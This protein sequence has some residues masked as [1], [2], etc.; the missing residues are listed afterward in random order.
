VRRN[1]VLFAVAVLGMVPA[2]ARA[3]DETRP[4]F[5][6][7]DTNA[8]SH[9][10]ENARTLL[11]AG[12]TTRAAVEVQHVLDQHRDDLKAV[13]DD[14]FQTLWISGR[15]AAIRLLEGAKPEQREAYEVASAP[16]AAALLE[17][18]VGAGDDR[19]LAQVVDRYGPTT[20]GIT[21]ARRIAD[22][23][24]E[25]GR[26]YDAAAAAA[27]ALR[28]APADVGL[29]LRRIDALAAAGD[30]PAL[31]ALAPPALATPDGG[32][33]P[34]AARLAA[35]RRAVPLA[36][37]AAG[38][39]TWGGGP[40]HDRA[41]DADP[42][43]KS[44]RW[45]TEDFVLPRS[46][47]FSGINYNGSDAGQGRYL[48]RRRLSAPYFPALLDRRLLHA[49]GLSVRS[50]DL[51]TG[52]TLWA[53]PAD[54]RGAPGLPLVAQGPRGELQGR[55]NLDVVHAPAVDGGLVYASVE[56][57]GPYHPRFIVQI[58][59]T[60]YLPKRVLVA[61]DAAT[62]ARVWHMGERP[63][64][65][66]RLEGM[67]V[68]GPVA[69]ADGVVVA[70]LTRNEER[71][72]V[73]LAGFESRTGR[74]LWVRDLVAGQQEL[75][76]FGQTVK[77]L[78]VG[79]P[80]IADGVAYAPTGLGVFAALDLRTGAVLWMSS[81]EALPVQRVDLWWAT[82]MRFADWGPAPVVV[83]GDAVLVA[84]SDSHYLWC[85][86]RGT[87]KVRW[88]Q[89]AESDGRS[90]DYLDQFL[91]VHDDGS[92]ALAVLSS[93]DRV[94]ALDIR[95]GKRAWDSPSFERGEVPRGRGAVTGTSAWVS[96][97]RGLLRFDLG[98]GGRPAGRLLSRDPWP[99]GAEPGNVLPFP[100]VLVVT[101]QGDQGRRSA[102]QAFFSPEDL[103]R[104]LKARKA[105]APDDPENAFEVAELWR[106]VGDE[107]RAEAEYKEALRL[108]TAAKNEA[109]ATSARQGLQWVERSRGQVFV[110]QRKPAEARA[111]FERA[112]SYATGPGDRIA[113]RLMLDAVLASL[114]ESAARVVNFEAIVREG[115]SERAQFDLVDGEVPAR[116]GALLAMAA[117]LRSGDR[118]ETAV[119]ALQR[120]LE[121]E[122]DATIGGETARARVRREIDAIVAVSGPTAYARHEAAAKARLAEA[123]DSGDPAAYERILDLWPNA[124]TVPAALLGLAER[125][126]VA[127]SH[128]AAAATLRRLVASYPEHELAPKALARLSRALAASGA[129]EAAR[130]ALDA[131]AR[132]HGTSAFDLD[133][134]RF[135]GASFAETERVRIGAAAEAPPERPLSPPLTDRTTIETP[136]G[137]GVGAHVVPVASPRAGPFAS[138]L[139]VDTG[140]EVVAIDPETA[141]VRFRV[142]IRVASHAVVV[143]DLLVIASPDALTAVDPMSGDLRWRREIHAAAIKA[144]EARAG[145]VVL[146]ESEQGARTGSRLTAVDAFTSQPS[147]TVDMPGE[148]GVRMWVTDDVAVV[149][150][151]KRTG[152]GNVVTASVHSLLTGALVRTVP[153][154]TE[155][156]LE[157]LTLLLDART[158]VVGIRESRGTR[159]EAIDLPA[160]TP[161]WSRLVD[162]SQGRIAHLVAA[163]DGILAIDPEGRLRTLSAKDG[164]TTRE[165]RAQGWGDALS[166]TV[167]HA[168]ADRLVVFQRDGGA[169]AV[170]VAAYDR[171]T[172]KRAWTQPIKERV[173]SGILLKR[174]DV[175]IATAAISG[176]QRGRA[177]ARVVTYLVSARDGS[178]LQTLQNQQLNGVP[179]AAVFDGTLLLA[180]HGEAHVFR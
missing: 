66:A 34:V 84:P 57:A 174:G 151:R 110:A 40:R 44:L 156:G 126:A 117:L 152:R 122:G 77:E 179:T 50:V 136:G 17:R 105:A 1:S 131:L 29:W 130:A 14:G 172:G 45:T 91:G 97:T 39:P 124:S 160:A 82:P 153:L 49:D 6:V 146:L 168:D 81:T 60:T 133:G 69:V 28:F 73:A 94:Y 95:S 4:P 10:V 141:D 138:P 75:N 125:Q 112:L 135:T 121:L 15:E 90:S 119:D 171:E 59:I 56:V 120:L 7:R 169:S 162:D 170:A 51:Y 79:G 2:A 177:P 85:F 101:T 48:Q 54:E 86:D 30:A 27:G 32:A 140:A 18:A 68:G 67:S 129:K 104:T 166:D 100:E 62:G 107:K 148:A 47:D 61:L 46:L 16:A 127:G 103:E 157:P 118:P 26:F 154:T 106:S 87:G 149:V 89:G 70:P 155:A 5:I 83:H 76:L 88:R 12:E 93:L 92:R 113:I 64:D 147:W 128:A 74:L 161:R 65:R 98:G 8:A 180:G 63:E 31:A 111:A 116:A 145:Q 173:A 55:T 114:R 137:S 22:A 109:V 123:Q 158:L 21:A 144:L 99:D 53:F 3:A 143:G 36:K 142:P 33:D 78:W 176:P 52:R 42:A 102:M 159:V 139:L 25:S 150:K 164:T 175:L 11:A 13:S 20:P 178:L 165:T 134:D 96:T 167:P 58:E 71:W 80:A 19:L 43:V 108:A 35:A 24:F 163:P 72:T 37:S 41:F 23:A 9:A 38:W 132:R 115:E